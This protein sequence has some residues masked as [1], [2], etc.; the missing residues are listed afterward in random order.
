MMHGIP[1][2]IK[3]PKKKNASHVGA[4]RAL[5]QDTIAEPELVAPSPR[6]GRKNKRYNGFSL[7]SFTVE[8]ED[9]GRFPIYTDNRDKVPEVDV[10]E[11]NPFID[12]P[13]NGD[14][15][16]SKRLA[17]GSKRRKI[18]A[19]KRVDPQVQEAINKDEGMVYVL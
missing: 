16:R 7:E 5:F 3:T 1:T 14:G 12:R 19:G 10:S 17:G 11:S 4:A 8:D 18:T 2:P 6:R 13:I 9:S 15:A